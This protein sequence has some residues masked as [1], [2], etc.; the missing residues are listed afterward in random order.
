MFIWLQAVCCWSESY[1]TGNG[2]GPKHSRPDT[3]PVSPS[4]C[5][6]VWLSSVLLLFRVLHFLPLTSSTCCAVPFCPLRFCHSLLVNL[7][8]PLLSALVRLF[9]PTP[10]VFHTEDLLVLSAALTVMTGVVV[11][12]L[13]LNSGTNH[14]TNHTLVEHPIG[15]GSYKEHQ[16]GRLYYDKA[17]FDWCKL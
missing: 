7:G 4:F 11:T 14:G 8:K 15:V 9:T 2:V 1:Q 17:L 13:K 12:D 10:F 6:S 5:L 3:L 16:R